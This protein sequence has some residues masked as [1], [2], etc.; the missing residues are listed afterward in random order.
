MQNNPEDD[1]ITRLVFLV[2]VIIVVS[3][4]FLTR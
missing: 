2:I 1:L 4:W 3:V